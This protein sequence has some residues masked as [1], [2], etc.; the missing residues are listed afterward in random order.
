[1]TSGKTYTFTVDARNGGS[2]YW[3][4]L[5]F[6]DTNTSTYIPAAGV[7]GLRMNSGELQIWKNGNY[8]GSA[9]YAD[10]TVNNQFKLVLDT[11]SGSAWTIRYFL[12]GSVDPIYTM[13]VAPSLDINYVMLNSNNGGGTTSIFDNVL[14]T[15]DEG[16]PL[17]TTTTTVVSSNYTTTFGDPVTFTATIVPTPDSGAFPAGNVQFTLDGTTDLGLVEVTQV[18]STSHGTAATTSITTIPVGSAHVVTAVYIPAAGFNTSTGTL[19]PNQTVLIPD[20]TTTTTVASSQN[21]STFGGPVTFTAMIVPYPDSGAFPAGNIQFT[22]DGTTDLGL[23]AVTQVGS[24]SHGTA[25]TTSITTIPAGSAHVITAEYLPATGSGFFTSTGTLSPNQNVL[26]IGQAAIV[27]DTFTRV[28]ALLNGIAPE[29]G[30]GTW[31]SV[32]SGASSIVGG[33]V[34]ITNGSAYIPIGAVTSGHIYTASVDATQGGSWYWLGLAFSTAN[35]SPN[36][37]DTGLWGMRSNGGTVQVFNPD[38]VGYDV[39]GTT[40]ATHNFKIVLDTTNPTWSETFFVDGASVYTQ[41]GMTPFAVNYVALNSNGVNTFDNVL[42][43]VEGGAVSNPYDTWA[44]HYAGGGTPGEDSNNDGVQ[45]GVAYFMDERG[46]ATN[47]G[48][49]D[50]KVTWPHLNPVAS[51]EVQVSANLKDWVPVDPGDIDITDPTKVIYTLPKV[52]LKQFC[53]LVVTP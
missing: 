21:P 52:E 33:A 9:A 32:G 16:T 48:L 23:V 53:R 29:T 28:D 46:L 6:A 41:S 5:A 49:K 2:W 20:G 8:E 27:S 40:P 39:A 1:M 24:T 47:P 22:L 15:V 3:A 10:F 44:G 11:T 36:F 31:N 50:G 45:N 34:Q 18:G 38:Y 13:T 12:N 7:Y 4:G 37:P 26:P 43:T 25:A 35:T 19:S 14:V 17:V 30:T 42:V 51:F